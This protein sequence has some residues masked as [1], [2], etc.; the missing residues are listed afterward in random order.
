MFVTGRC[1][2]IGYVIIRPSMI[3]LVVG[4]CG[5]VHCDWV[6]LAVI[7]GAILESI[8]EFLASSLRSEL[9]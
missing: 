7:S 8:F 1:S 9:N 6:E 2:L 4:W 3:V 5:F